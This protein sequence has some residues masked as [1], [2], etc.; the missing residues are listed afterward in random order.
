MAGH[1]AA[2][3]DA[4]GVPVIEP[5]QAAAA[6]ALQAVIAGRAASVEAAA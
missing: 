6:L 5:C 4:C 1:R 2:V 3:E